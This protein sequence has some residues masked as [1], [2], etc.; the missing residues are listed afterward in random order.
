MAVGVAHPEGLR[1]GGSFKI[2][3]VRGVSSWHRRGYGAGW[4]LGLCAAFRDTIFILW[5]VRGLAGGFGNQ[6]LTQDCWDVTVR[7]RYRTV[8]EFCCEVW[9]TEEPRLLAAVEED[10]SEAPFP[11]AERYHQRVVH[12]LIDSDWKPRA[13][14]QLG[15]SLHVSWAELSGA[16]VLDPGQG[17]HGRVGPEIRRPTPHFFL[18]P[19]RSKEG[20]EQGRK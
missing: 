12:H 10:P 18:L 4:R 9:Q 15:R 1:E 11:V 7:F 8:H 2:R 3:R 14:L 5:S 19:Y 20:L 13:G 17:S 6:L 16:A